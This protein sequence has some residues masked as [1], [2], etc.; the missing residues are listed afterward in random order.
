[1][2]LPDGKSFARSVSKKAQEI[3]EGIISVYK[4][5]VAEGLNMEI[6]AT[7]REK[8]KGKY[9]DKEIEQLILNFDN[10]NNVP[11]KLKTL[12]LAVSYDMG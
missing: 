1:M 9:T 3:S 8:V 11:D 5:V 12:G 10:N 6:A 4:A 2:G 7:I